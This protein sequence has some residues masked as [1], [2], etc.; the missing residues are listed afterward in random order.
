MAVYW[1]HPFIKAIMYFDT[2]FGTAAFLPILIGSIFLSILLFIVVILSYVESLRGIKIVVISFVLFVISAF[3]MVFYNLRQL[4]YYVE[5]EYTAAHLVRDMISS[6]VIVI[7]FCVS[8]YPFYA[9]YE[10]MIQKRVT[11]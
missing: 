6:L 8:L 10:V 3:L 4:F 2:E 5:L 9:E 7:M 1:V 11:Y